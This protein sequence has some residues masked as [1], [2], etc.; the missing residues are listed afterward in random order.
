MNL[1][2][3][4]VQFSPLP[5]EIEFINVALIL[6]GDR[7]RIVFEDSFPKL[8]CIAPNFD[9]ELLEVS[10]HGLDRTL[11][12]ASVA[13]AHR[14]VNAYSAQLRAVEA[15]PIHGSIDDA[16]VV[17]RRR[18]LSRPQRAESIQ[19]QESRVSDDEEGLDRMLGALGVPQHMLIRH[20]KPADYLTRPVM[21][22]LG[23][24]G[25]RTARV[26]NGRRHLLLLDGLFL[27]GSGAALT[28]RVGKISFGFYRMGEVRSAVEDIE[29]R[30]L[31][32]VLVLMGK[33]NETDPHVQF[34]HRDLDL[35]EHASTPSPELRRLVQEAS[36]TQAQS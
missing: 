23:S 3:N 27:G 28:Q 2:Y 34:V 31:A 29:H 21:R 9:T 1:A 30:K 14:V 10:L 7:P 15:R 6:W 32:R 36:L 33:D 12:A 24:N 22:R 4:L 26:I 8:R 17:L 18:F 20:A 13:E 16:A 19:A 25:F 5:E 11:Q 35:L